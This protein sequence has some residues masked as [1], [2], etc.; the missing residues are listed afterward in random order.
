MDG[1][2][3]NLREHVAALLASRSDGY[4]L[5]GAFF[6]DEAL[7]Q[8]ELELHLCHGTGSSWHAG[9]EIPEGGD[10]RTYQIGPYPIFLL[11]R[12]DGS[13]RRLP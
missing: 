2:R 7:Y 9:A 12:D 1:L 11:R 6:A 8:A 13:D 5:P 4:A 3:V 10:Y